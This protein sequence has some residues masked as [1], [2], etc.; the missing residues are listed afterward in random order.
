MQARHKDLILSTQGR[1]FWILD[2]VTPLHQLSESIAQSDVHIYEPRDAYRVNNIAGGGDDDDSE[3][4][5]TPEPPPGDAL[6]TYY[7]AK[8]SEDE[9]T[10]EILDSSDQ[11]VRSY[12]SDEEKAKERKLEKLSQEAGTHR[13]AWNLTYPG[14]DII[15]GIITFG[16]GGG[17][18]APPGTYRVRLTVG[19]NVQ[20]QSFQVL[21]DPRL[22]DVTQQDFDEQF[23]LASEIR[24][25]MDELYNSIR[26]VRSVRE[27]VAAVAERAKKAGFDEAVQETADAVKKKLEEAEGLMVQTKNQSRQDPFR[28]PP[29]L[30][31]QFVALYE[32]VT[33]VD[34]YRAG[35]PEGKPTAGAHQRFDDLKTEWSAA[36]AELQGALE[37]VSVFNQKLNEAGVPPIILKQ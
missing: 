26:R 14:P 7:L 13:V 2:D 28:F 10:L 21:A 5:I 37:E 3:G 33:G 24:D 1:S 30:V 22:D 35:G 36:K 25:T 18:K 23:R 9:V 19:D 31:N 34:G 29:Q 27:Q 4:G 32:Y 17:V 11:V 8:E 15:P 20:T 12:T 16:Y 6:M